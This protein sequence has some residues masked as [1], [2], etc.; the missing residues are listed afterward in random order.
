MTALPSTMYGFDIHVCPLG[1]IGAGA[2]YECIYL[3]RQHLQDVSISVIVSGLD[4]QRIRIVG[5]EIAP[6][7]GGSCRYPVMEPGLGA[8][9]CLRRRRREA[10]SAVRSG[11]QSSGAVAISTEMD[12]WIPLR[13]F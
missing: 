12:G 5:T 11:A 8:G 1:L 13:V 3:D 9:L 2:V 10:R 6:H 7:K 4:V